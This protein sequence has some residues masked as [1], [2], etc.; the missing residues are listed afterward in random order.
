[1]MTSKN[2]LASMLE[3]VIW[4]FKIRFRIFE[5]FSTGGPMVA[6][7]GLPVPGDI[8]IQNASWSNASISNVTFGNRKTVTKSNVQNQNFKLTWDQN[9]N[10]YEDHFL[11]SLE[12]FRWILTD[13][14]SHQLSIF[15][16]WKILFKVVL[17]VLQ[18]SRMFI[19][20][21][22]KFVWRLLLFTENTRLL[23]MAVLSGIPHLCF[24]RHGQ[25]W[26]WRRLW[27]E[28]HG[29]GRSCSQEIRHARYWPTGTKRL[30]VYLFDMFVHC[31]YNYHAVQAHR[32]EI[33]KWQKY[34]VF[35]LF[36]LEV[37]VFK[38]FL[39][40]SYVIASH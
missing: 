23:D 8:P 38:S 16:T 36:S 29:H 4:S 12:G 1:M 37:L 39:D 3:R 6:T 5:K 14:S 19:F 20:K 21:F 28:P 32:K 25:E 33:K 30:D 35:Q 2:L 18:L 9:E 34:K 24:E 40:K 10:D 7:G 31:V 17:T 22:E 15:Y 27:K 26:V 13:P 11:W